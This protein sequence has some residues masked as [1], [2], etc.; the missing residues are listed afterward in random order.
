MSSCQVEAELNELDKAEAAEY[1]E[2]LGV[3]EGGL[4]ALIQA[5]YRQLGLLTYFTT[6]GYHISPTLCVALRKFG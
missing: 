3:T 5:T 6:G 2:S 4:G 1:L